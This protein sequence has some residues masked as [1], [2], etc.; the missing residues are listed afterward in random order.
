MAESPINLRDAKARLSELVGRA[1]AGEVVTISR[2][3]RVVAQL[4]AVPGAREPVDA[5]ALRSL[6]RQ[7]PHAEQDAE[8][9]LRRMREDAR[10]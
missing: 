10:Y 3:G 8:T 4:I 6:T 1:E 5:D 2:R 7:L 9:L